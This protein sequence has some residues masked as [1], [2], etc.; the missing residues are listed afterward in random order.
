MGGPLH[1]KHVMH[2]QRITAIPRF[3]H[4]AVAVPRLVL[5]CPAKLLR[6]HRVATA[7]P[8]LSPSEHHLAGWGVDRCPA[9]G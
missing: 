6:C 5:S 2:R 8:Y 7:L 4:A 3:A 9:D 1:K